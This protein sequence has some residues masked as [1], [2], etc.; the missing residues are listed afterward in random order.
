M[1]TDVLP[2]PD[3][4]REDISDELIAVLCYGRQVGS[5]GI[6]GYQLGWHHGKYRP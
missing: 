5:A 6:A 1:K 4:T 3:S 2:E